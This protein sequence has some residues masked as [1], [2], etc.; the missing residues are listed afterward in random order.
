M[1]LA[2]L[3]AVYGTASVICFFAY[4]IDKSAARKGRRRT[5]ERTL[6]L[7]GLACGWPGG[8]LAQQWLRHKSIKTSF[9]LKFWATV[10]LNLALLAALLWCLQAAG[11][12]LGHFILRPQG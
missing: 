9:R 10:A 7:L 5:P 3:L 1:I 11:V 8:L 2:A 12:S 4:A 6:L